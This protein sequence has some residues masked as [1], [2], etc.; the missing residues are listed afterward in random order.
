MKKHSR[1][2]PLL[3][4]AF[5]AVLISAIAA[6]GDSS[7]PLVSLSYLNGI[8]ASTVDSQVSSKLDASDTAL[9]NTTTQK[10]QNSGSACSASWTESRQKNGDILSGS[11]GLNVI[12]LAGGIKA[13][14]PS[15]T[16][17]DV[18]TGTTIPSGTALTV[19]HRYLVAEDTTASFTVTSKTAVVDVQ[20]CYTFT[21]SSTVDYNAMATA[22]KTMHLFK[23]SFT[24]YGSGYDLELAPTRLQALIM[25]IRVLGEENAALSY[26][27]S[28]PFT[29]ITAGTD[30]AKY[31]GY[32][33]AKGYTNGYTATRW[34]PA[35]AVNVY[36]YSEF[37]LRALGYSSIANTDLSGTLNRAVSCG[38]LTSGETAMLK[39]ASFLR[40][41]LV[42][43]SY[44][45]L[46]ATVSGSTSTLRDALVAKG[47]FTS[48]EAD[49]A[50]TLV[51]GSR[52]A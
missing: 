3:F 36:Q 28:T 7:D 5:S 41:D 2:V 15:G 9:L 34:N 1:I 12:L 47:V 48:A 30:A 26:T 40:A 16:V 6:G 46:D 4:L 44:Y 50:K 24:G 51:T 10:L 18:S 35:R 52:V 38:V 42:Y 21:Y 31:V 33:Y 39:S 13:T 20:G 8:Y 27:G 43:I 11:S 22:L 23:G 45:A 25:F 19:N 17:V 37:V 29:D 14:F 49:S 32:A